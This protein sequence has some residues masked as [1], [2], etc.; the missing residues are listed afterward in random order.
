VSRSLASVTLHGARDDDPGGSRT[1]RP[2]RLG[3][4]TLKNRTIKRRPSRERPR[5]GVTDELIE[6]HVERRPGVA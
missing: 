4:I 2:V 1:F 5:R 3:P 6:F